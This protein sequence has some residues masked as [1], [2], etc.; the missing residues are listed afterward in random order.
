MA[1]WAES[2]TGQRPETRPWH[3]VNIARRADGFDHRRDCV[4]GHCAVAAIEL[5]GRGLRDATRLI[6]ER[7]EALDFLVHFV[8]DLH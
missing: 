4:D 6:A 2:I 3:Y 8:G 7:R 1:S 5:Q